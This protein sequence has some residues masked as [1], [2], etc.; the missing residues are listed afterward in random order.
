MKNGYGLSAIMRHRAASLQG[1]SA[2]FPF[3]C[4]PDFVVRRGR[5]AA[6]VDESKL[7]GLVGLLPE[8]RAV[9]SKFSQTYLVS[10]F[11]QLSQPRTGSRSLWAAG[12]HT[13][14]RPR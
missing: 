9:R 2:E 12:I 13:E 3:L 11:V 4:Y 5:N 7:N 10:K 8:I 14:A 6:A 1:G